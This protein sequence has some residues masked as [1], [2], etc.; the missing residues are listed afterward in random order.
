MQK[1]KLNIHKN[2]EIVETIV[3]EVLKDSTKS[4]KDIEQ[5]LRKNPLK[6]GD[7]ASKGAV[8]NSLDK[9]E[10]SK[11]DKQIFIEKFRMKKIRTASGV[12]PVTV[13]TKPFPC[14]GKCI[15]C[16]NDTRMPKSYLSDEPGAQRAE[17]NYFDPYFQTY[18]RLAAL[19]N[20]GHSISK[21]ELII[22]GGT[23]SSYPKSYQIWFVKRCF[24]AMNNFY[25]TDQKLKKPSAVKSPIKKTEDIKGENITKTYNQVISTALDRQQELKEK[26][27]FSKL[28]KAQKLNEE[29]KIKC[30][31]LSI[32]T[33]P[34]EIN[35][36][37]VINI[38]KLGATKVQIGVQS[39]NDKV[40]GLNKRGH[41]KKQTAK[42]LK[43]LRKAG[44]KLHAHYMPNLYGSSPSEDIK[45]FKKVFGEKDFRVDEIK[46]YPCSLIQSA[47]LMKY[48][49]NGSWKPYTKAELLYVLC[50]IYKQVPQYC[51]VT[52]VVRDIPSTDIVDGNKLTNFR[53]IVEKELSDNGIEL[54][55]IRSREIRH[56][57]VKKEDLKLKVIKYK[58]SIGDEYFLQYVTRD[59][60]IAGF[61]RLS[62]PSTK[63]NYIKELANCSVI[64]EVHV[65]GEAVDVGEVRK[66]KAQHLGLGKSLIKKAEDI[67]KKHDFNKIAVISSIGTR[68]YYSKLGYNLIDLYQVKN[69]KTH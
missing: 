22:L 34:D 7:I 65:Y 18:N 8:I 43:L 66:G 61:L 31:G 67:S 37:E 5:I 40:L 4:N 26:A 33:R 19:K 51:R 32:E 64:R 14:P 25:N 48:Y 57:K 54:K 62:L 10:I 53:Q 9:I 35:E 16:P 13:L 44:F 2:R 59:N 56:K 15:F 45:D 68:Q 50:E 46:V 20:T 28:F 63:S 1:Y 38:R 55:D 69:F 11:K 3:K 42:A 52:R 30:I 27:T 36:M 49:K 23:W 58:T 39:L 21:V 17:S 41:D 12:S 24:D 29:A 6:E 60:Q 47:E